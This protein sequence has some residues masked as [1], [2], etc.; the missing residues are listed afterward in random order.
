MREGVRLAI[1]GAGALMVIG[2]VAMVSIE[3]GLALAGAVLVFVANSYLGG[4]DDDA[5]DQQGD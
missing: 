2:A 3:G 5:G 1:E 4:E